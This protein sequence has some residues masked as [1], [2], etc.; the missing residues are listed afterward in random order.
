MAVATAPVS[1]SE[2]AASRGLAAVLRLEMAAKGGALPFHRF[3]ALALYHPEHGYY[4]GRRSRIGRDGDFVTAPEMTSLFGQL[5]TLQWIEVWERLGR[6][7]LFQVVEAGAGTGVLAADILATA[8]RF[9]A[10]HAALTYTIIEISP[11]FRRRQAETL[12]AAGAAMDRVFWLDRVE[13]LGAVEGVIFSNEFLDALPVHWLEMT[14]D[15]LREIAVMERD[16]RLETTLIPLTPPLAPD[17]LTRQGIDLPVGG[18]AEVGV[19]AAAWM[20]A[21]GRAL[22]RGLLLGI[23]YGYVASEYNSAALA[24]GTLVGHW[25]HQRV[26]DPLRHPG[27]MDLT[28]HVNFSAMAEAG[29][30]SGLERLGYASQAWFLMGLGILE[31]MQALIARD[32]AG[33]GSERLRQTVLRLTMP[34][35]MGERFKVLALGRGLGDGALGGFR[36]KNSKDRLSSADSF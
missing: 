14:A 7:G 23:D 15:G 9:P 11:D 29:E 35:G 5:L 17:C 30:G 31:R 36:L 2:T 6:P 8:R 12:A 26:D 32:P 21:A 18:R 1:V 24:E 25:R 27:E 3:M 33:E 34:Q 28:A 19:A 10:F 22:R 20:A 4:M 16:G 13:E